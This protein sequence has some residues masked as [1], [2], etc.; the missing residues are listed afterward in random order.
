MGTTTSAA[1]V[2]KEVH[3]LDRVRPAMAKA[4]QVSPTP[5]TALVRLALVAACGTMKAAAIDMQIDQSQLNRD[6]EAGKF[7]FARIDALTEAQRAKFYEAMY[8]EHEPLTSPLGRL[9]ELRRQQESIINEVMQIA[10]GMV[11]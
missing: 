4:V 2:S 3:S 7:Q 6:I 1:R 11:G 9:R 8:R 10:E 5:S